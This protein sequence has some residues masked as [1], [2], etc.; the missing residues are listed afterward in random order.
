MK[1]S[2]YAM[3]SRMKYIARWGLMR[4]TREEN[5]AEHTL[6][7]AQLAHALAEIGNRRLGRG[8]D[9]GRVAL[10][11][12]YHDCAEIITG[13]LPTPVKYYNSRIRES[14]RDIE[15]GAEDTLLDLLPDDLRPAYE[16]LFGPGR[17]DPETER[18]VKA[19]DKL[20][21][22]LKCIEE[23]KA[24][25]RE[26]ALARRSTEQALDELALPEAEIFR[27]EFLEP[28]GLTLDELR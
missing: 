5:L 16:G 27:R 26:F 7:V 12:L 13:D 25:N 1:N 17:D 9:P 22:L 18:L 14:Y 19:A 28:Y 4:N 20:S 10:A 2:F 8:Y 23:E 15:R 3:L 24:G 21:A 11:A 6:E